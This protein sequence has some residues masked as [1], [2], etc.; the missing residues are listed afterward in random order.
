MWLSVSNTLPFES[1][2]VY[3]ISARI[4]F[5]IQSNKVVYKSDINECIR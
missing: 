1:V 2:F 3:N 5:Q 4:P